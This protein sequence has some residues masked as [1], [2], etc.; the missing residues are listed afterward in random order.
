MSAVMRVL[1]WSVVLQRELSRKVKFSIYRSIY[2]PTLT[3][4]HNL[5]VVTE[6]MISRIQ[7]VRMSFLCRVARLNLRDRVRSS[8][9]RRE[10][11]V[12]LLLL[13]LKGSQLR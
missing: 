1:Y 3:F 2:F 13:C 12:G 10:L 6:R 5:W 4:G 9:I 11:A 7:V 8:D